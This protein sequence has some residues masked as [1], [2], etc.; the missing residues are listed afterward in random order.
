MSEN[1]QKINKFANSNV[2]IISEKK[3]MF[4]S[5]KFFYKINKNIFERKLIFS[6]NRKKLRRKLFFKAK[7]IFFW[8]FFFEEMKNT[9]NFSTRQAIT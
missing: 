3:N 9:K 7:N 8:K 1:V 2:Q 5:R 4:F 6:K